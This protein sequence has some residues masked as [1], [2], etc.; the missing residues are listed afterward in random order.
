MFWWYPVSPVPQGHLTSDEGQ[1]RP[2][3]MSHVNIRIT[4]VTMHMAFEFLGTAQI[5][6][7]DLCLVLYIPLKSM[8]TGCPQ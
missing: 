4:A 1:E 8:K 3:A 7:V 2:A 5:M 6:V